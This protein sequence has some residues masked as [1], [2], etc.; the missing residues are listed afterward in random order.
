M[1]AKHR[2]PDA[3][4]HEG[5]RL[6]ADEAPHGPHRLVGLPHNGRCH[7]R[8]HISGDLR[9]A[10]KMP[11][12]GGEGARGGGTRRARVTGSLPSD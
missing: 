12:E 6:L 10:R 2:T 9:D 7:Q 8:G 3:R 1:V 11:P 5:S 4:L